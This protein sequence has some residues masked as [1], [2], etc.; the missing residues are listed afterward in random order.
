MA[1]T[2][3]EGSGR[4]S[5]HYKSYGLDFGSTD[6]IVLDTL[7]KYYKRLD[8]LW[9]GKQK[10]PNMTEVTVKVDN[11]NPDT[12][13]VNGVE[14]ERKVPVPTLEERVIAE[15]DCWNMCGRTIEYC[16]HKIGTQLASFHRDNTHRA[17]MKL[18]CLHARQILKLKGVE[19]GKIGD[20]YSKHDQRDLTWK[21][22]E[23]LGLYH[24]SPRVPHITNI[25]LASLRWLM[26]D[27]ES[28]SK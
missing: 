28:N 2:G 13:T 15:L 5:N 26:N 11:N 7:R 20:A 10:E 3:F 6:E 17:D 25:Y 19:V 14:Y 22:C 8:L 23:G 21:V 9:N 18:I 1:T 27:L 12:V 4:V 16:L 24:Y